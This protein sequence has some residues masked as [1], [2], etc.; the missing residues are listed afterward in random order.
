MTETI[1]I[2]VHP[3]LEYSSEVSDYNG[4]NISCYGL[5]N[6]YINID[7][8]PELA[9]F[10]FKWDGPGGFTASTEDISRLKAGTIYFDYCRQKYV[11]DKGYF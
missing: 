3:R 8:S 9:P 11:H 7:P 5:S 1:D 6:G 4:Y 2:W 10:T